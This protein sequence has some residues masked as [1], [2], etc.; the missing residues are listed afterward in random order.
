MDRRRRRERHMT[1][2]G[3]SCR[4]LSKSYGNVAAL[5]N[6]NMRVQG[7]TITGL[8]GPNGAG[9]TT[10]L[11]CMAGIIPATTGEVR[12]DGIVMNSDA[13]AAKRLSCFVPDT[14]HLF[15]YLTV[16]EHLRF[17]GRI[18]SLK[19]IDSR[20][21]SLLRV[22][23]LQDKAAALPQSLSRGMKQKVA[24]CLGFLHDPRAVILD[25]PLTGLDPLGIRSMKDAIL[26][27]A[28]NQGAAV[29]VSSH[30]LELM[31]EICDE[32]VLLDKGRCVASG[33]RDE[34]Q[35]RLNA[36]VSGL[37]LEEI[38]L[39]LVEEERARVRQ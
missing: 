12:I 1:E 21:A 25:E 36:S 24:I 7:G 20:V 9:K 6:L 8:I 3:I 30:Q 35:A 39:R 32:I 38:F 2:R 17:A 37:S 15:D 19:D 26:D 34:L 33:T 31:E 29:V 11:R 16:E 28:K 22:F 13:V 27:R 5:D 10:A 14:P 4:N 23:E 18:H